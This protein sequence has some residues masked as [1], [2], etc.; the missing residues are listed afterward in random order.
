MVD[1]KSEWVLALDYWAL[2]LNYKPE[3]VYK[4]DYKP[5]WAFKCIVI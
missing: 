2:M 3:L 1:Y 5:K 4:V